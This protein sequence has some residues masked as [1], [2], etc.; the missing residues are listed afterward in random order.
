MIALHLQPYNRTFYLPKAFIQTALAGSLI[1]IALQE[2]PNATEIPIPN[3]DVA[4]EAIQ[5]L[6]DY[7]QGKEPEHHIPNLIPAE[8]Y[9][10]IPWMLYY[11]DP[12]YDDIP[13]RNQPNNPVNRDVIETALKTDHEL[14]IGYFLAKGWMPE[15]ADWS[16]ALFYYSPKVLQLLVTDIHIN[17]GDNTVSLQVAAEHD[18]LKLVQSLMRDKRIKTFQRDAALQAAA[19]RNLPEMLQ[20][21]LS[22]PDVN[23]NPV[24]LYGSSPE[25]KNEYDAETIQILL[26]DPRVTAKTKNTAFHNAVESD[27]ADFIEQLYRDPE[28]KPTLDDVVTAKAKGYVNIHIL[29]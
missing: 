17:P 27:E 25:M 13:M 11:V 18:N 4:P 6:V 12:L 16:R 26:N 3:L 2:D 5:F 14:I 23:P 24:V 9:L 28:V 22:D 1:D 7:S 8:R 10:N 20:Q 21:L 29:L 15:Q 19:S